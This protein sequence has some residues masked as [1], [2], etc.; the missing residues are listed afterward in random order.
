MF[1]EK[2]FILYETTLKVII[3]FKREQVDEDLALQVNN[4]LE[5]IKKAQQTIHQGDNN[6]K[7]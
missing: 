5:F 7:L 4:N 3:L 2:T 6:T 1:Y